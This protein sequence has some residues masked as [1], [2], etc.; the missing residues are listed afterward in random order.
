MSNFQEKLKD[1]AK[2]L[3]T[4]MVTHDAEEWPPTF[5]VLAYQP[6]R[7]VQQADCQQTTIEDETA[8]PSSK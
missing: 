5:F 8:S 3:V 6:M 7:P 4:N 2:A 1:A